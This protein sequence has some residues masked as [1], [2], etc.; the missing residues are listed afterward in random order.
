M[1]TIKKIHKK[2]ESYGNMK[3]GGQCSLFSFEQKSGMAI[4]WT[5][6]TECVIMTREKRSV[7]YA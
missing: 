6:C 7:I 5:F 3:G 4:Y 1:M 2:T